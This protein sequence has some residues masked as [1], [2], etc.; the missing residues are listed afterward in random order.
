MKLGTLGPKSSFSEKAALL[1]EP[2]AKI[3]FY[4]DVFDVVQGVIIKDIAYGAIP[5]ENSAE[6]GLCA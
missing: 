4:G 2:D 1:W 3:T 6:K 5:I